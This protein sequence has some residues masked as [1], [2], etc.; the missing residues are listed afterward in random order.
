MKKKLLFAG[1]VSLLLAV[2]IF[3]CSQEKFV[4]MVGMAATLRSLYR[5]TTVARCSTKCSTLGKPME[6][7]FK[8]AFKDVANHIKTKYE[9]LGNSTP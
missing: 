9:R 4:D 2:G 7:V 8:Y 6:A 3:S 1:I 5:A